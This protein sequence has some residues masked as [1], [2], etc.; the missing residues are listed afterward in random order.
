MSVGRK[1][2]PTYLKLVKGTARAGRTPP[3]EPKPRGNLD[4][5]PPDLSPAELELWNYYKENAPLGLLTNVDREILRMWCGSCAL[6]SRAAADVAKRGPYLK[7]KRRKV[8][9]RWRYPKPGEETP[10][11]SVW[12]MNKQALIARGFASELGFSPA[13][14]TR[15]DLSSTLPMTPH[16]K[17]EADQKALEFDL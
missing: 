7:P 2:T 3:N 5:P 4:T 8:N 9:G 13:A 15:I 16:G 17:D 11:P 1:P 12:T 10:N 14:R 6:Y